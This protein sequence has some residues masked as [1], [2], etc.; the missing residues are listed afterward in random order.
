M[1]FV[2]GGSLVVPGLQGGLCELRARGAGPAAPLVS[3]ETCGGHLWPVARVPAAQLA[4]VAARPRLRRAGKVSLLAAV[5]AEAAVADA[6]LRAA[7]ALCMPAVFA[8]SDGGVAYTA[9]FFA[10]VCAKG[11]GAGSPLLFPETVYNAPASH[12][13]ALLGTPAETITLVG[14]ASAAIAAVAH[15]SLLLESHPRVLVLAANESEPIACAGYSRWG[16]LE[17]AFSKSGHILA[18]GAAALVLSNSPGQAPHARIEAARCGKGF[19]SK[20]GLCG[21]LRELLTGLKPGP[22]ARFISACRGTVFA[23]AESEAASG[24]FCNAQQHDFKKRWGESLAASPLVATV[25]W[26]AGLLEGESGDSAVVS[27]VGFSGGV[28][29]LHLTR[30]D[31]WEQKEK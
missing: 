17:T 5:A 2:T 25:A 27:G 12:C 13:A 8:T 4:G 18:D 1:I 6:G 29:V 28:A 7:E 14:D 9:R 10:D 21:S 15:A 31:G 16:F 23:S 30:F 24:I 26:L 19:R 20:D 22:Q 3:H 11:T